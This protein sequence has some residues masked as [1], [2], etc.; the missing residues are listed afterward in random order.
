VARSL[1]EISIQ[2]AAF[3][4]MQLFYFGPV[5]RKENRV[6]NEQ[7]VSGLAGH[8]LLLLGVVCHWP[9][10]CGGFRWSPRKPKAKRQQPLWG[11]RCCPIRQ[12]PFQ[13]KIQNEFQHIKKSIMAS[14]NISR[15]LMNETSGH[16][17]KT[18][19]I[20]ILAIL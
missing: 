17:A 16:M 4:G 3:F 8:P 1:V 5:S 13:I 12:G 15:I 2:K 20:R 9:K 6:K 10:S 19:R 14:F 11:I 18:T 7:G